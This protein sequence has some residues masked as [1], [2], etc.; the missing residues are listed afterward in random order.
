MTGDIS[1]RRCTYL[2]DVAKIVRGLL[3][4]VI[5]TSSVQCEGNSGLS[6]AQGV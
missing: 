2:V 3:R 1:C 4:S 5:R 6:G